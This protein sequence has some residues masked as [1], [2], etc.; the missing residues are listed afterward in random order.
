[1]LVLLTL[2][3]GC[4]PDPGEATQQVGYRSTLEGPDSGER[5]NI[6]I[7]EVLWSGTVRG[8]GS[9]AQRDATDIFIEIRNQGSRPV[10]MTDWRLEQDG[11]ILKS[12][13][14]PDTGRKIEVGEHAY[15]ATRTDGCLL[16]PDWVIE[17]LVLPQGDPF[18]LTLLDPDEHLIEGAGSKSHR[19]FAGGY[20]LVV[21]RS[22]ERIELMF[23]GR[24]TEPH[25]WHSYTPTAVDV[26]NNDKID[27]ECQPYTHASP[28]R[29]N[30][31][32]YSGAY[33]S[34]SFE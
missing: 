13:N 4:N 19:P 25:M 10:D 8:S 26:P 2:L 12:W 30:S 7:S 1:M 3:F 6:I 11:T 16:D 27:P 14:F 18:R 23:G 32:D 29:A 9:D 31:P 17:D 28:G 5:G 15:I 22:M 20:D 34:G 33:A 21:S 24:G